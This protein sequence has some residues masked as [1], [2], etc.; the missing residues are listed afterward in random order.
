M[1]MAACGKR[2]L[3]PPQM[4][5]PVALSTIDRARRCHS[6]TRFRSSSSAAGALA[7]HQRQKPPSPLHL[8]NPPRSLSGIKDVAAGSRTIRSVIRRQS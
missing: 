4:L 8:P 1:K 2:T 7:P 5:G 6:H 3:R